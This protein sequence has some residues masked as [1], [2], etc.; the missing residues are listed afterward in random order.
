MKKILSILL[1]GVL[2]ISGFYASAISIRN[3]YLQSSLSL[4]EYDMVIIAPT[5]FFD[6]IQPL[7][8]HKN[9]YGVKTFLMTTEEI[10]NEYEGSD[11]P[12]QIKLFI[13]DAIEKSNI[14]YV[15]LV[16]GLK[17]YL[18]NN[19]RDTINYGEEYWYVPVRYSNIVEPRAYKYYDPGFI[20][21]LYYADIYNKNGTFSSWDTDNNGIYGEWN[22]RDISSSRKDI[23]DLYPDVCVGRLACRN[24][25]EVNIVVNK[26]IT[27]E[28]KS[29]GEEWHKK[30][31]LAGG[32]NFKD[33]ENYFEGEILCEYVYNNYMS[34]F[35]P[36]KLY[37]S[38][39]NKDIQNIPTPKN[40]IRDFSLGCGFFYIDGHGNPGKIRT[41]WTNEIEEFNTIIDI[42]HIL[43]LKNGNKLPIAL[44]GGCENAHINISIFYPSLKNNIEMN[45]YWDIIGMSCPKSLC[46]GFVSK[47]GGGS[48]ASIGYNA[49]AYV[50]NQFEGKDLDGNGIDEPDYIEERHGFI[51]QS[52]FKGIDDGVDILGEAWAGAITRY[53]NTWPVMDQWL[54]AKN[55]QVWILLGDP[56][57]KI[58][59]YH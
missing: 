26:I 41:C 56:S 9:N 33:R 5:E 53:L 52:F 28:S 14:K 10:Y 39:L 55:L 23:L 59:G 22:L 11:K 42:T 29:N 17:H 58:G 49:I 34:E 7:I 4:D 12:E 16:G 21:D 19:P 15:L 30:I 1:I 46:W 37:A 57:L 48:I 40:L 35:N 45:G 50:S 13:K 36:I 38:N 54:D 44:F 18:W 24:K 3:P 6:V 47:K 8:N 20:S 27:Y 2:V 43:R 32:N 25:Y 51:I 31:I